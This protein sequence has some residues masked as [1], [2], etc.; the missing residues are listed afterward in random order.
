MGPAYLGRMLLSRQEIW[1]SVRLV[2]PPLPHA[3]GER[4]K[5]HEPPDHAQAEA[6]QHLVRVVHPPTSLCDEEPLRLPHAVPIY[7]EDLAGLLLLRLLRPAEDAAR[8]A[9][10]VETVAAEIL[11]HQVLVY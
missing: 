7:G 2:R 11:V 5:V 8:V 3:T 10:R 4:R 9:R 6:V 1:Q